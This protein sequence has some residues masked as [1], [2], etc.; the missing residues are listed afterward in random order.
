[1][2]SPPITVVFVHCGSVSVA[3]TTYL[4]IALM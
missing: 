1:M 4:A 3:D 2:A